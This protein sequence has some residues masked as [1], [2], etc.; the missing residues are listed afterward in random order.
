MD[1]FKDDSAPDKGIFVYGTQGVGKSLCMYS[2]AKQCLLFCHQQREAELAKARKGE[3]WF[4]QTDNAKIQSVSD[5]VGILRFREF[6]QGITQNHF[7][8]IGE[9]D[10]LCAKRFV[11]LDDMTVRKDQTGNPESPYRWAY[12]AVNELVNRI[13]DEGEQTKI[14]VTSNNTPEELAIAFGDWCMDRFRGICVPI[15]VVGPS[16]R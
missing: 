13:W 16:F 9:I 8:I 7:D 14:Y 12:D 10:K 5:R 11:F 4:E 1:G 15:H 3:D 2:I 6:L